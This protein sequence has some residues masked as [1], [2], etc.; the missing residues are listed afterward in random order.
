MVRPAGNND[1]ARIVQLIVSERAVRCEADAKLGSLAR[2]STT[3]IEQTVDHEVGAGWTGFRWFVFESG[4]RVVGAVRVGLIPC[5]PI[6]HLG[7]QSAGIVLDCAEDETSEAFGPL[8]IAAESDVRKRGAAILLAAASE[9]DAGRAK[10]LTTNGYEPV[11]HFLLKSR[12]EHHSATDARPAIAEDVS[13]IVALNAEAR[14]R[15]REANA[16]MWESHPDAAA[17]F[18]AWM[19]YSLSLPDR[20]MIV[21]PKSGDVTGFVIAQPASPLQVPLAFERESVGLIDDFHCATF[22]TSLMTPGPSA[23]GSALLSA[24]ERDLM[25]R[26]KDR[27]VAICPTAWTAK[28]RFLTRHGYEPMTT[29]FV[30][31]V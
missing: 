23:I 18:G 14:A 11:T 10:V 16:L 6:Y 19:G 17:R 27:A 2:A 5:P 31:A 7:G 28:L 12:L 29:W 1:V 20:T 22:G 26:G 9:R 3:H 25:E 13:V 24:A 8:L 30:K 4:G 21:A 15:L